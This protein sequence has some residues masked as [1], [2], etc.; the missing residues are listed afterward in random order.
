MSDVVDNDDGVPRSMARRKKGELPKTYV[1]PVAE[2]DKQFNRPCDRTKHLKTHER[3]HKCSDASCE[4]S[5][6][7]FPTEK[8]RD[9]HWS[10]RHD[11]NAKTWEC[12]FK[13]SDNCPYSSK[14]E[15]NLKSHMEKAHGWEYVRSKGVKNVSKP[16][17]DV[18]LHTQEKGKVAVKPRSS[19]ASASTQSTP[20]TISDASPTDSAHL[21][22]FT[23]ISPYSTH[24][25][26]SPM[27]SLIDH[28]PTNLNYDY[29]GDFNTDM[30]GASSLAIP[31]S[32]PYTPSLSDGRRY[33]EFSS[34]NG[35]PVL[36]GNNGMSHGLAFGDIPTTIPPTPDD[37]DFSNSLFTKNWNN[38][39]DSAMAYENVIYEESGSHIIS[40]SA[41][42]FSSQTHPGLRNDL[43][44][45]TT[46]TTSQDYTEAGPDAERAEDKAFEGLDFQLD[47]YMSSTGVNGA[48]FE[49]G[50]GFDE[51][52]SG[53]DETGS[54]LNDMGS[55]LDLDNSVDTNPYKIYFPEIQ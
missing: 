19:I 53:F 16:V 51:M 29:T 40:P 8:E 18:D 25:G 38:Q 42:G 3:P 34:S 39:A 6:K 46:F 5:T 49:D 37:L 26:P 2:C 31:D 48:L 45:T 15:H 9:R 22:V 12:Q 24:A 21:G 10:D 11:P 27:E 50:T 23:P 41:Y 7:G 13:D 44:F 1:C 20:F 28:N 17:D 36:T 52:G 35:T 14:R 32:Y 47:H 43:T 33:S 54:Q 30:F 4:F 55:Q